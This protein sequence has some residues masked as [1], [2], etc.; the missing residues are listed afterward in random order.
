MNVWCV[1]V[2]VMAEIKQKITATPNVGGDVRYIFLL[3]HV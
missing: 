2:C 3:K 1:S